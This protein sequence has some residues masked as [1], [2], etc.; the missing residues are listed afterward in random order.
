MVG[1]L[2][3]SGE[4]SWPGPTQVTGA[5]RW[6][7]CTPLQR[8]LHRGDTLGLDPPEYVMD[9]ARRTEASLHRTLSCIAHS[10]C[11]MSS[12]SCPNCLCSS[13]MGRVPALGLFCPNLVLHALK[14][15]SIV[16]MN[17]SR[18]DLLVHCIPVMAP[19]C[20]V[21]MQSSASSSVES[22]GGS[23]VAGL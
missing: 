3:F 12:T 6:L 18:L 11:T 2:N 4:G 17:G 16:V 23:P 1:P 10:S 19:P 9:W 20:T 7:S 5:G 8:P 21:T 13:A 14:A 22:H 15:L